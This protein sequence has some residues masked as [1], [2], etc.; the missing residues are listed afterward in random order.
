MGHMTQPTASSTEG[1]QLVSQPGKGSIPPDQVLSR[2]SE[3]SIILTKKTY[4]A[5]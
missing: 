2:Q 3:V 5:P 1:Q 4:I